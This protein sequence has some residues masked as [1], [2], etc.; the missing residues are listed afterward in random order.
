MP[1]ENTILVIDKCRVTGVSFGGT[2]AYSIDESHVEPPPASE[3][4]D[5]RQDDQEDQSDAE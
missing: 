5:S 2:L 3:D 4:M 1:E